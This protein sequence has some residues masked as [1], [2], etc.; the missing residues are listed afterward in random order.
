MKIYREDIYKLIE[1][2][3]KDARFSTK[4]KQILIKI[5]KEINNIVYIEIR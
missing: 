1:I 4:E 3:L 5:Q 2:A